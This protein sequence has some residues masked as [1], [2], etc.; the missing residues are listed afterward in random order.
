[1]VNEV[2]KFLYLALTCHLYHL[3]FCRLL[4]AASPSAEVSRPFVLHEHISSDR[5]YYSVYEALVKIILES[6]LGPSRSLPY[7]LLRMYL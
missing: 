1:M 3:L 2:A 6:C 7:H 5:K 4:L